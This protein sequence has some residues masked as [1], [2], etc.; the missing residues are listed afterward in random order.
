[1]KAVVFEKIGVVKVVDV[2]KPVRE[3]QED[4]LI[5]ITHTSICGTDLHI[6]DG[7]IPVD[8]HTVIGHE[9]VGVVE[10]VG[11]NVNRVKVGDRVAIS[12]GVQCGECINCRN[13]LP[14]LCERGGIMGSGPRMGNFPGAQ[15]E[16]LRV[17]FADAMLE[18]IPPE[19]SEEQALFVGDILSTGYMASE[20]GGIRPGNVVAIFGAGPV[21]LCSLACARL[22]GP[23]QVISVD[24]LDYR[25]DFAKRLGAD[26]VVNASSKSP[27]DEIMNAT[28]GRGADVVIEAVGSA[29]TLSNC[30]E[31]VRGGGHISIVGVFPPGNVEISLKKMLL[32]NLQIRVGLVNV[33]NMP[34]LLALLKHGKLDMSS[35]ISHR[36]P[37]C[38]AEEAYR[39]FG[40][41]LD[42]VQKVVLTSSCE[43][44]A[45]VS[46]D[47]APVR[48][49]PAAE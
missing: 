39:I 13:G 40:A 4:A 47:Q 1:M 42:N 11:S 7:A 33:V 32:Q 28:D 22:F 34:R 24:V 8:P 49:S 12:C 10:E 29:K 48:I 35:L 27:V 25:L 26:I 14:A 3:T 43:G 23:S 15:A 38:Q 21:G 30:I 2:P 37:L 41:K 46:S 18:P 44:R 5:R 20:N 36:M 45:S 6:L 16:Y 17:P 31:S 9:A 19:L